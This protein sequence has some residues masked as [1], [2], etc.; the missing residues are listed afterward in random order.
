MGLP[1]RAER[2]RV[3]I[4]QRRRHGAPNRKAIEISR[5]STIAGNAPGRSGAATRAVW[6]KARSSG[7]PGMGNTVPG[8]RSMT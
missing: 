8:P 5:H 2:N 6:L 4:H 1:G 3:D 7:N